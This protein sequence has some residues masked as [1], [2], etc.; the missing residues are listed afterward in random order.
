[1]TLLVTVTGRDRPG[2]TAALFDVLSLY[3]VAV[4]DIEQ[5][6]LHGRLLLGVAVDEAAGRPSRGAAAH[7]PDGGPQEVGAGSA[8]PDPGESALSAGDLAQRVDL[9]SA[10]VARA[11][12]LD[13]S[14]EFTALPADE[15]VGVPTRHHVTVLAAPLPPGAVAAVTRRVAACGGNIEGINRLSASPAQAYELLVSGGETADLRRQLAAEAVTQSIDVA[16]ERSSLHRRGRRLVVMDVDSTLVRGEVI[17]MLAAEAGC[18]EEVA[19]VTEAA[20]LGELDFEESL[21]ARVLLLAGLP[22]AAVDRVRAAVQLAPGAR[23]LVRTLHRLGYAV[24]I[25]SGGFT[26]VTDDLVAELGLDHALANVLEI[27]DGRVT[28]Q[29][30]GA[31][32]DRA[33]KA[34]ALRRFAAAE[35]LS[36]AQTVAVGDGAND[37]DMLAAAG[38]GIA[39]NAKPV[40]REAADTAISVPFLDAVLP[41]LGVRLEDLDAADLAD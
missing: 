36:M 22:V 6:V 34:D 13:V 5:V 20:M 7:R 29:V 41:L 33:A 12:E 9:R 15:P 21:R 18:A 37:L 32:V 1:M 14:V 27:R 8:P 19:E 26:V 17:E 31:V 11:A 2:V 39:F 16:V 24:G 30:V 4:T 3:D 35:G 10:L 23:T 25:V 40:V 38:L 28:G